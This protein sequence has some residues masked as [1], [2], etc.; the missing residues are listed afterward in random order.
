M[1]IAA[2]PDLIFLADTVCCDQNAETVAARDGWEEITAVTEDRVF[3]MDDDVASRWGPRIVEYY[4]AVA[5]AVI[6]TAGEPAGG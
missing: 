5:D 4:Q 6:A 1:I 2:D 3:E